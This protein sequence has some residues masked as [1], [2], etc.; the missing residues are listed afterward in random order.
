[1]DLKLPEGSSLKA[2]QAEVNRLENYL[3]TQD[4][5][6]SNYVVYTG[7]GSTSAFIYH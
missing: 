5:Y 2:T 1:M 3:K 6:I 7:N 4:Q